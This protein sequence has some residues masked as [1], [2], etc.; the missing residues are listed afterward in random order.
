MD[1]DFPS[2]ETPLLFGHA[3]PTAERTR[4]FY[5]SDSVHAGRIKAGS[6]PLQDGCLPFQP[7]PD[8][9]LFMCRSNAL[10]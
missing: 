5:S 10:L 1:S 4:D 8:Q 7:P 3:L 2:P 6:L 9:K